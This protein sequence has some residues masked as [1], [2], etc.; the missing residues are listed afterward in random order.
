MRTISTLIGLTVLTSLSACDTTTDDVVLGADDP[1]GRISGIV[2]DVG[3]TGLAGVEVTAHG[4]TVLTDDAGH[5]T[6][7]MVDPGQE[8]LIKF[9]KQGYSENARYANIVSWE[10]ASANA[11]LK[12][13]DWTQTFDPS[14]GGD[15]EG[16]GMR[17]SVPA[18]AVTLDGQVYTG[19]VEVSV[20]YFDPYSDELAA[21]PGDLTALRKGSD[22]TGK[23]VLEQAQLLSFGMVEVIFRADDQEQLSLGEPIEVA[24]PISQSGMPD[25]YQVTDGDEILLWDWDDASGAWLEEGTGRVT[26]DTSGNSTYTFSTSS[27]GG[28]NPDSPIEYTCVQGHIVD[29]LDFDVRGAQV[30]CRGQLTSSTVTADENGNFECTVAVGDTVYIVPNTYVADQTWYGF[31]SL[32]ATSSECDDVGDVKIEVCRESGVMMA[33]NVV[34]YS[35]TGHWEADNLRAWFWEPKGY[36]D[37]CHNPWKDIGLDDCQLLNIEVATSWFPDLDPE[38]GIMKNTKSV[39]AWLDVKT[40]RDT[41]R[42]ESSLTDSGV[43]VYHHERHEDAS[44]DSDGQLTVE[45]PNDV[46]LQ[47]GDVLMTSAPGNPGDYM[48][49]WSNEEWIRLPSEMSL[50]SSTASLSIQRGQN[51]SLSYQGADNNADDILVFALTDEADTALV[52]RVKDDGTINISG[53]YTAHLSADDGGSISFYKA[54]VGW[55]AGPDGLPIRMQGLTGM[56]MSLD[57]Q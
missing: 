9:Q 3:Q 18:G 27:P 21:A 24:I 43:P 55:K 41:Y 5:Y 17:V 38:T 48:G 25:Y 31:D 28:K 11:T 53:Q 54:D 35:D 33:D 56:T 37:Y 6:L 14:V 51:L 50:T 7:E 40:S 29:T 44:Y 42:L 10:T 19:D 2:V 13:H 30:E 46:D 23:N 26:T 47:G 32:V 20:T 49:S 52:C 8:I 12:A 36:V 1:H 4:Q 16:D 34:A 45:G 57:I 39:G 15:F 22:S